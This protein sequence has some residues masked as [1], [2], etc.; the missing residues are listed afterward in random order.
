MIVQKMS[1]GA[2]QHDVV[3]KR[4]KVRYNSLNKIKKWTTV[5]TWSSGP[6]AITNYLSEFMKRINNY[7][8]KKP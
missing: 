1:W 6:F 7:S 3:H 4:R 2:Y 8:I 5:R